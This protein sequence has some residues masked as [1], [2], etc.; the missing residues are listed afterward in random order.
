MM[1]DRRNTYA[2][3]PLAALALALPLSGPALAQQDDFVQHFNAQLEAR[4]LCAEAECDSGPRLLQGES[5]AYP[6]SDL[7]RRTQ[8]RV[9][10]EFEIQ[11]DGRVAQPKVHWSNSATLRES[12]LRA[13]SAWQFAPAER[14]G[15]AVPLQV[16]QLF[17]FQLGSS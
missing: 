16:R 1:T 7:W 9:L 3:L 14:E 5:P 12:A 15:Q 10:L 17:V 11:A 6:Q 2:R 4:E 8:G 13:V